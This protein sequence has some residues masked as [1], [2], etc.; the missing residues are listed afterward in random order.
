MLITDK[1]NLRD[2]RT[3]TVFGREFRELN[4]QKKDARLLL[5]IRVRPEKLT[6]TTFC[7]TEAT[8]KKILNL[9]RL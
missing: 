9:L 2:F 8:M 5:F 6:E 3:G 1:K 7:Y 4:I